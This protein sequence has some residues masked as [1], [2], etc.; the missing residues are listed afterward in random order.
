MSLSG[1]KI[2]R[3]AQVHLK[4][5]N[6]A[7]AEKL[8]KQILLKFPKNQKTI[9]RY[10][11]LKAELNLKESS[12]SAPEQKRINELISLYNQGRFEEVLNTIKPLISL[13]PK[14]IFLINLQG[15]SNAALQRYEAAIACYKIAIKIKPDYA[16]AY[17]NM[18]VA[19]KEKGELNAAIE[20]YKKAIK[21]RPD[22][23][24]AYYNM[25]VALK[26]EGDAD[27]AIDSYKKALKINPDHAETYN[28]MGVALKEKGEL[29]AA[30]DNYK[31][32]IKIKPDYAEAYYNTGIALNGEGELDTAIENYKQTIKIKPDHARAYNN[33]GISLKDKGDLEA[34]VDSYKQAIKIQPN[35]S[36]AYNNMGATLKEK[37]DLDAAI[38]S[39]RQALKIKPD[40]F[41]AV[42]NLTE[43]PV[44]SLIGEDLDYIKGFLNKFASN[45]AIVGDREFLEAGY[46]MHSGEKKLAF[47]K[48]CEANESKMLT[49]RDSFEDEK[50]QFKFYSQKVDGWKNTKLA[51]KSN[52]LKKLFIL[53][54]SRSGKSTLEKILSKSTKIK[55]LY[56]VHKDILQDGSNLNLE[57]QLDFEALFFEQENKIIKQGYEVIT[58][59]DPHLLYSV[60]YLADKLPNAHFIFVNRDQKNV[61][62][63]I[64]IKDYRQGNYYSYDPHAIVKYLDFYKAVAD[65]LEEKAPSIITKLTFEQIIENPS[66]VIQII[67]DFTSV[68]LSSSNFVFEDR[69]RLN[70]NIFQNYF[71]KLILNG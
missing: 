61:A 20:I 16:D 42:K 55:P 62:P 54:P 66:S 6:S 26:D 50:N 40:Y 59:T 12:I 36:A 70:H 38:I 2:L 27:A 17:N 9:H 58:S 19:L 10:Q 46:L 64:F 32:A 71:Q 44:G 5:G 29:N 67:A 39:Y 43:L 13:F 48:F 49:L 4:A 68:D 7:E 33:M 60:M 25:G 45:L 11:Q 34:A 52:T 14:A 8:Y 56:E 18:G 53:G 65:K 47:T 57:G 63:E 37:S 28:N 21:I 30:M 15:A 3:Q 41:E 23:A 69:R 1:D 35:F 22:Y 51:T 31:Q 24:D